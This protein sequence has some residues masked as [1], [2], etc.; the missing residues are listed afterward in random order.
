MP[1]ASINGL[2][3]YYELTDFTRPWEGE[4]EVLLLLHGLYG[5]LQW[6]NY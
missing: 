1:F 4:P 6:W 3:L 5:H 2:Q